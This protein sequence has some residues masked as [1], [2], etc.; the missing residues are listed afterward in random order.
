MM[1]NR[2]CV[3][4]T[5]QW[6][7]HAVVAEPHCGSF[8]TRNLT[9]SRSTVIAE[10]LQ[11]TAQAGHKF[12]GFQKWLWLTRASQQTLAAAG[13]Q[14]LQCAI[15]TLIRLK[16]KQPVQMQDKTTATRKIL[17]W[18]KVTKHDSVSK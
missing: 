3:E 7:R 1:R 9:K 11:A 18:G 6:R 5:G 15:S 12:Y 13:L 2:E 17:H 4:K 8:P 16:K 14:S 10:G